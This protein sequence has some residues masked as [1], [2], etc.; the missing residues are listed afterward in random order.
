MLLHEAGAQR[1]LIHELLETGH[2]HPQQPLEHVGL[3][4]LRAARVVV[5]LAHN[6]GRDASAQPLRDRE[7]E[8]TKGVSPLLGRGR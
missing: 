2:I 5:P 8:E 1:Q 3:A 6:V 4:L 7:R